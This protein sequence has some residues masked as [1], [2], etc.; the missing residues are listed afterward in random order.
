MC[1]DFVLARTLKGPGGTVILLV[2]IHPRSSP[3][4]KLPVRSIFG[5]SIK[6]EVK[7]G[8]DN[9]KRRVWNGQFQPLQH[10][11]SNGVSSAIRRI[12]AQGIERYFF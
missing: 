12:K 9:R 7:F 1:C 4:G 6:P 8:T 2:V 3:L 5:K 10:Y 11:I